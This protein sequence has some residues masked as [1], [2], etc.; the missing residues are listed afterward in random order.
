MFVETLKKLAEWDGQHFGGDVMFDIHE[1]LVD[2]FGAEPEHHVIPICYE[3]H[4]MEACFGE[5]EGEVVVYGDRIKALLR[6]VE[7]G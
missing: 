7:Q 5:A 4:L 6:L 2:E 3:L 1:S